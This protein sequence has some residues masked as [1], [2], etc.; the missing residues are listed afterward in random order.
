MAGRHL[1]RE[2]N[3]H[4]PFTLKGGRVTFR[5][6]DSALLQRLG[7]DQRHDRDSGDCL[8]SADP[9]QE[10]TG[11]LES[12]ENVKRER[13]QEWEVVMIERAPKRAR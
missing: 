4:G 10:F 9:I 11:R 2:N 7:I 3:V 12:V 5:T 6:G 13:P 8:L 1:N